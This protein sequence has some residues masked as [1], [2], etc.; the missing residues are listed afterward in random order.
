MPGLNYSQNVDP[1]VSV[2]VRMLIGLRARLRDA[3]SHIKMPQKTFVFI[4]F[5]F[6]LLITD[7]QSLWKIQFEQKGLI[8]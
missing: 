1:C 2:C 3:S 4:F 6:V 8:N 7:D 5:A